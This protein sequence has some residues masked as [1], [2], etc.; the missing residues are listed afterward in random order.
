MTP[1]EI[2]RDHNHDEKEPVTDDASN[3]ATPPV[4]HSSSSSKELNTSMRYGPKCL[5]IS[6]LA[7]FNAR[8]FA[9][10][11][12]SPYPEREGL[13][14][15]SSGLVIEQRNH[16]VESRSMSLNPPCWRVGSAGVDAGPVARGVEE[17]ERVLGYVQVASV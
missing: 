3:N 4:A 2:E 12:E 8:C 1:G 11:S 9:A 5:S 13:S 6:A 14:G 17:R 15:L 7:L 16:I 10:F